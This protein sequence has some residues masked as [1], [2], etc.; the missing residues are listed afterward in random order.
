MW[1]HQKVLRV[2]G[3]IIE[4]PE[5]G[6]LQQS[7]WLETRHNQHPL[8]SLVLLGFQVC[9]VQFVCFYLQDGLV[10][11]S[12]QNGRKTLFSFTHNPKQCL[13]ISIFINCWSQKIPSVYLFCCSLVAVCKPAGCGRCSIVSTFSTHL[14]DMQVI[15]DSPPPLRTGRNECVSRN[16][17]T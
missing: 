2:W 11:L 15:S 5:D 9:D 1:L 4:R 13:S 7:E 10:C 8:S 3:T 17:D 6:P 14:C 12:A 16:K